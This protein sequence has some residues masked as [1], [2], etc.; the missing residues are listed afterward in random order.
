LPARTEAERIP[1]AATSVDVVVTGPSTSAGS[2]AAPAAH[3]VL[4]GAAV[5]QLADVVNSLPVWPP[6][7]YSCPADFGYTD[8]LTFSGPG[9]EIE[10]TA[11]VSGC[12]G[13]TV[14]S[15]GPLSP[16][17]AGGGRVD[18]AVMAA[19][20]LTRERDGS[21]RSSTAAPSS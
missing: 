17:L 19:L 7:T 4:S 2:G 8:V 1:A 20:G 9:V 13:V 12:Q 5:R 15:A 11:D 10:V 18:A 3:R 16:Q 14:A 6:G 21:V